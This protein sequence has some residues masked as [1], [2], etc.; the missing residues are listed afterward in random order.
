MKH[1]LITTIAAVVLVGCGGSKSFTE[2]IS[3]PWTWVAIL[4]FLYSVLSAVL[5][6]VLSSVLGGAIILV[7]YFLVNF[8]SPKHGGKTGEELKAEGK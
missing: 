2:I 6:S 8:L 5:F 3:N 7:G 1:I 4:P